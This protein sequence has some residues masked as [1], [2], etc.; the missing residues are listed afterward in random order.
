MQD[1]VKPNPSMEHRPGCWVSETEWP[2]H[3]QNHARYYISQ[4]GLQKKQNSN[5]EL[6]EL[7][8]S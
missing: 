4:D 2:P 5:S 1:P 7:S 8:N 6:I 3:N